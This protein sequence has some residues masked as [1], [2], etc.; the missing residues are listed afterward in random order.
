MKV[1]NIGKK[2]RSL[3]R[4][5]SHRQRI[6]LLLDG[7]LLG[8]VLAFYV[9]FFIPRDAVAMFQM[10][11]QRSGNIESITQDMSLE[12]EISVNSKEVSELKKIKS[13]TLKC[14][15]QI[16]LQVKQGKGGES[17]IRKTVVTLEEKTSTFRSHTYYDGK[18]N[19]EYRLDGSLWKEKEA[20]EGQALEITNLL[21]VSDAVLAE[22]T[23]A[24][25][26]GIYQVTIPAKEVGVLPV[27]SLL[28]Q[29]EKSS[30][31]GGNYVY[32][33]D[34][35]SKRLVQIRSKNLRI[36][37]PDAKAD[38]KCSVKISFTE[39]NNLADKDW[40]VPDK[41]RK[42]AAQKSSKKTNKVYTLS[43]A[44][45]KERE[46]ESYVVGKDFPVG[47]YVTG[48]RS[49][50]GIIT[51]IRH[52]DA[53]VKFEWNCG[54]GYYGI[55]NYKHGKEVQLGEGDRIIVSGKDLSIPFRKK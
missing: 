38:Q 10:A 3:F 49:G 37:V 15:I 53:S 27:A 18:T 12:T 31:S 25:G 6:F 28:R 41:V 34:K 51:C 17:R 35:H 23:F 33:F 16:Q 54:Y 50:E 13:G 55:D 1:R 22:S 44:D 29:P 30:I 48:K 2:I 14:P 43:V 20:T 24:R 8:V 26:D 47:T 7:L 45:L 9:L 32:C 40:K 39:Y 11:N 46:Q 5:M 52:K 36:R 4:R 19:R 42:S 21:K